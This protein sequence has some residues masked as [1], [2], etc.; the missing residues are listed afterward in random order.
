MSYYCIIIVIRSSHFLIIIAQSFVTIHDLIK[1][2]TTNYFL[3]II[4]NRL[5]SFS[6]EIMQKPNLREIP[7]TKDGVKIKFYRL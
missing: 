1:I 4:I 5:S 2:I 6:R 3:L 7:N